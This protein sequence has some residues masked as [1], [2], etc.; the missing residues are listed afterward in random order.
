MVEMIVVSIHGM[1][2]RLFVDALGVQ[3][4]SLGVQCRSCVDALRVQYRLSI[5]ALRVRALVG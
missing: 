4:R 3:Y 5:D 1:Q 2:Y